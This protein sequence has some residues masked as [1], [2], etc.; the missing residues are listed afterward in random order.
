MAKP[1]AR[2]VSWSRRVKGTPLRILVPL[3]YTP[4]A[5]RAL[6]YAR[7]LV[8]ATAG[9]LRLVR[10]TDLDDDAT[11]FSLARTAALLEHDGVPVEWSVIGG[12]DAQTA[13]RDTAA[14]WQP[15]LIT[16]ATT[17]VSGFDRWLNGSV[18][19]AVLKT[20]RTPVLLVPRD[21]D[22]TLVERGRPRILV[23]LDG[24]RS[25]ERR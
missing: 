2:W 8:T 21:W 15:D 24:S 6:A 16:L 18:A 7:V 19:E 1:G 13:I 17:K 10:A 11:P 14:E 3:D 9:Q 25:E 20:V 5:Q 23:A 12:V 4:Q 22:R